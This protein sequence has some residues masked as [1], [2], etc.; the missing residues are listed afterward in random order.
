MEMCTI[1]KENSSEILLYI[2][3]TFLRSYESKYTFKKEK[4]LSEF[5][6]IFSKSISYQ[7]MLSLVHEK[8]Y[9]VPRN[10]NVSISIS[11]QKVLFFYPCAS[12]VIYPLKTRK[13][14]GKR[15]LWNS[16]FCKSQ[17]HIR[18]LEISYKDVY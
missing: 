4:I 1:L 11:F 12:N 5:H 16:H 3:G 9:Y 2:S 10:F 6:Y 14:R 7:K 15:N 18:S 8:N 13:M 17:S